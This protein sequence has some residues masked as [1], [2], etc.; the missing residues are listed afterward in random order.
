MRLFGN[1]G[2]SDLLER[3]P[4][5]GGNRL[6]AGET[7]LFPGDAGAAELFQHYLTIDAAPGWE[8]LVVAITLQALPETSPGIEL[9]RPAGARGDFRAFQNELNRGLQSVFGAD[10]RIY[11]FQFFHS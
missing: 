5:A 9:P 10:A 2:R 7:L 3:A 4:R 1:E 11:L 8:S 6:E